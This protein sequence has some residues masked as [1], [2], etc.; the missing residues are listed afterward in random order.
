LFAKAI[1]ESPYMFSTP[2]LKEAKHGAPSSEQLGVNMMT[3]MHVPDIATLRTMDAEKLL[4]GSIAAGFPTAGAIDGHILPRQIVETFKKGEQAPVPLMAGFTSGEIRSLAIVAPPQVASAAEYEAIIRDR[5]QDL[6]DEFLRLYPST[7]VRESALAAVRDAVFGWSVEQMIRTQTALGQPAYYFFW[8]HGYPA[9][10]AAGLH[11]SHTGEVP[12]V[13]GALDHLPRLWPQ[14][15]LTP[16]EWAL[17]DAVIGYWTSFARTGKPEAAKAPAWP[18]YGS[19][20]S[21]MEFKDVPKAS[22]HP[23]PGMYE[24]IEQVFC[25]RRA[26]GTQP[27]NWTES[28]AAQKLPPKTDACN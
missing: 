17:S 8:D 16:E 23:L 6:A 18:A 14:M 28:T 24:L 10:D 26:S 25:R 11:A 22:T 20:A 15:P 7:N 27:W 4:E 5:Y 19:T 1:A 12:Y 3:A 13:F 21:Y 2:D 9:A